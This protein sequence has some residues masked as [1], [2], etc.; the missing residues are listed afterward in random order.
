MD[1]FL[2]KWMKNGPHYIYELAVYGDFIVL[3]RSSINLIIMY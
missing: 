3:K 2:S 1:E